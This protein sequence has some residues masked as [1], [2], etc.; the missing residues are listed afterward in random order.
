M[1]C[2]DSVGI[3]GMP[4][5]LLALCSFARASTMPGVASTYSEGE[6]QI[7]ATARPHCSVHHA[8]LSRQTW[9]LIVRD[10]IPFRSDGWER[11]ARCPKPRGCYLQ[12]LDRECTIK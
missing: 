12:V 10:V 8:G 2:E 5:V 6:W 7:D 4:L 9:P 3:L 1:V 11:P